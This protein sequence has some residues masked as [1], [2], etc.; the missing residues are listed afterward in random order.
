MNIKKFAFYMC[1]VAAFSSFALCSCT[2]KNTVEN[3]DNKN[4]TVKENPRID[5]AFSNNT[6]KSAI[7]TALS[8]PDGKV[9]QEDIDS[10]YYLGLYLD[11]NG[12][13]NLTLGQKDYRD[14]YFSELEKETP[15][16]YALAEY[17]KKADF[18]Y[19]FMSLDN[20]LKKF[21]NLEIFEIYN[22]QIFDVS[23]IKSY[24]NLVYGYFLNN[25]ITDVKSL[26]DY[27]PT[28]LSELDFSENAVT[29]WT[30]L[31]HLQ[32]KII[33]S[34][35]RKQIE[36]KNGQKQFEF[37]SVTLREYNEQQQ[38]IK[39]NLENSKVDASILFE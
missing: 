25:K 16:I 4:E 6:L 33:V 15:D 35:T 17:V 31:D 30:P 8:S 14:T 11:Q 5:V 38:Q 3:S 12:K 13:Y 9:T 37:K 1:L 7:S 32:D 29:D 28:K 27:N 34:T 20:D 2:H 39:E 19:D 21:R 23:F 36:D 26:S 24:E 22:V 18:E 10:V